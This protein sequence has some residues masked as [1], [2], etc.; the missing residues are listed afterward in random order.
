VFVDGNTNKMLIKNKN[1]K[2]AA[3]GCNVQKCLQ[4]TLSKC[5][6]YISAVHYIQ[7]LIAITGKHF[8]NAK[9][10][11]LLSSV[12]CKCELVGS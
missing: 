12:S 2:M 11:Y 3:I 7:Q 4:N 9:M 1:T 6:V 10:I 5:N 8:L